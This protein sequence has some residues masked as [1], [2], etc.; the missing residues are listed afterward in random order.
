MANANTKFRLRAAI[1]MDEIGEPRDI[2]VLRGVAR[3]LRG[4]PGLR[5]TWAEDSLD[6]S[7][8]WLS[9]TIRAA[10][11][12]DG[13]RPDPWNR[14]STEG[15]RSVVLP[16]SRSEMSS[17]AT[18]YWTPYGR[19]S[20][21]SWRSTPSTRPSTSSGA[22]LSRRTRRD[23]HPD[24][25]I[26]TRMSYGSTLSWLTSDLVVLGRRFAWPSEIRHPE[27]VDLV[28]DTYRGRFALDFAY[29]DWASPTG[30]PCTPPTGGHREGRP[31]DTNA[32]AYDRAIGLARRAI[33]TDPEA[34]QIELSLLQLY[35][36]TGAHA[37]A[38][39]QYEHYAAVLRNDLGIEP[40]PLDI[41]VMIGNV[42]Y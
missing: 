6:G 42:A 12:P 30:T 8:S 21:R 19:I 29:E 11:S 34:E 39:E 18:R 32:G 28:G 35:R 10:S 41:A 5:P 2:A 20:N 1:L 4:R 3:S 23:C 9:S 38:A 24:M 33:E 17:R 16:P 31:A 7:Q 22:S 26:T 15:S 27:N 36:R 25:S 13:R 40:P 14:H 37:A